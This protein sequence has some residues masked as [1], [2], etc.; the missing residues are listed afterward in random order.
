MNY[1]EILKI[2]RDADE[3]E[4]KNAYKKLVKKYHPDLFVADKEFAEKKI[5]E[6][7]EAYSIL[8]DPKSKDEYDEYLNEIDQEEIKDTA[9]ESQ[10]YQNDDYANNQ[11]LEHILII[12]WIL[13]KIE[14]LNKRTQIKI[15]LIFMF[16]L[17]VI[18]LNNLIKFRNSL[19]NSIKN[20]ENNVINNEYISPNYEQN[21]IENPYNSNNS[22]DYYYDEEMEK[23]FKEFYNSLMEEYM[24]MFSER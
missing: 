15:F 9:Y 17:L 19:E 6:I 5:K 8:S 10:N 3:N 14:K 12:N 4:I 22:Y 7:N 11:S 20:S 21:I 2:S 24:N 1:Y 16:I 23:Q 18:F 13:E